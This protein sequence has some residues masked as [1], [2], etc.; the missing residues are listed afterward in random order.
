MSKLRAICLVIPAVVAAALSLGPAAAARKTRSGHAR[1][2]LLI[3]VDGLHQSDLA[4][5][6]RTHPRSVLARLVGR[7]IEF[8]NAHTPVPSDSFPGMAA[9][10]TGGNPSTTGV[11]YDDTW[12]HAL[13]PAGTT[14]C[15]GVTPGVEATYF[16]ALDKNPHALDA[17]Q[18]LGGL[19][20]SI[21]S[22]TGKPTSLI[23]P[24]KL[25]V[26]P[27]TC[28]PVYP[29]SYLKVNT[30]FE[31]ARRA[32]LRTAWSD[33]HPAYDLLNGPSGTGV[34][35]LFTPEINSDAPTLGSS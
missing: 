2:V 19:P 15:A 29:H 23:D 13:L 20:S 17:G 16:E 8:K 33:K 34:Q 18:G 5:Y 12:N 26:D 32:G 14:H 22:M 27:A 6:V 9:Q 31:V 7:G 35:D 1:H 3:S 4:Y 25:P 24:T 21:L 11:Y 30:I 10:V 28:K